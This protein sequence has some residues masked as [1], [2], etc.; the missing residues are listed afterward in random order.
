MGSCTS[1][2]AWPRQDVKNLAC[3]KGS[4]VSIDKEN[5]DYRPIQGENHR[6]RTVAGSVAP[7]SRTSALCRVV[8]ELDSQTP[9]GVFE[10]PCSSP[11]WHLLGIEPLGPPGAQCVDERGLLQRTADGHSSQSFGCH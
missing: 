5:C 4:V 3:C 7:W 8:K 1:A 6:E 11:Q 9:L 10:G 2:A